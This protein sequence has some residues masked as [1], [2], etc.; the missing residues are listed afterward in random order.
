MFQGYTG[1]SSQQ[2]ARRPPGRRNDRNTGRC[3]RKGSE[4]SAFHV[5]VP[6]NVADYLVVPVQSRVGTLTVDVEI[7]CTQKEFALDTGSGISL[8]QPGVYTSEIKPTN[9]SPFGLTGKELEIKRVQDVLLHLGG[10]KFS[11][12]FCICS[13]PTEADG[14]L[15]VDF[16]AGK[17]AD[18][19]LEKSQLRLLI[20][21]ERS[22]GFESQ[23]TRHVKGK[24]SHGAL[25]VFLR[26]NGEGSSEERLAKVRKVEEKCDQEI[27]H[28]PLEM[29]LREG[30][31]WILKTTES[32]KLAPRVKQIVVGKTETPKRRKS[33]EIEAVEPVQSPQGVLAARGLERTFTKP[34]PSTRLQRAVNLATSSD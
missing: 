16:L 14:I 21:T 3:E 19:N 5:L 29:E 31:S 13:V 10:K 26:R 15:G 27:N 18:L 1:S 2:A 12:Q 34:Q 25:T 7:A 33:P 17:K 11:H 32:I 22:N 24:T 28:R 4:E 8:I 20:G 9:L 23:R 6:E 30:E